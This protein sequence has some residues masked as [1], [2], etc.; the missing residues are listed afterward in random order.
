MRIA[1]IGANGQLGSDLARV[2]GATHE[3]CSLMHADVEV[4]DAESVYG[5]VDRC[6]PDLVIN[7]AAF[8]RVDQCEE[9]AER[10]FA[11][12]AFGVRNLAAACRESETTLAHLSTDYVFGGDTT[13]CAP[14][15]EDDLPAPTNMY[16]VSKLAGEHIIKVL[17]ER[18]FIFRVAGLFGVAGSS[19]K[20]GNFVELMLRLAREGRSIRVVDDQRT[21]PT[22]TVDLARQIAAVIETEDY[23]LYHATSHGDCTWYEFASEIFRQSGMQ[24]ELAR[25]VTGDFGEKATRPGYSVLENAHLRR[26]GMD[27]MRPWQ[28][29]LSGYLAERAPAA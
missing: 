22:Y 17:L 20:G 12:N 23:G 10:A 11:V 25:A 1:L 13:R 14:Y 8:H 27:G 15:T 29:A 26:I 28:E 5:M 24:P 2:L 16:G 9:E 19:G 7:T 3:L 21:T 6:Q 4:T 18:H